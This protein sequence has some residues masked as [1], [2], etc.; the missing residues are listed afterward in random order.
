MEGV[1]AAAQHKGPSAMF[2]KHCKHCD[3]AK[4]NP[5]LCIYVYIKREVERMEGDP[6][7]ILWFCYWTLTLQNN[8]KLHCN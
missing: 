5:V 1:L 7:I 3:D 2:H 6:W 8:T 4:D